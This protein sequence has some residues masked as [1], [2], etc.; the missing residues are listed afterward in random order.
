MLAL[1]QEA[2]SL[3]GP[4]VQRDPLSA[5]ADVRSWVRFTQAGHI[6][7]TASERHLPVSAS[8]SS[9]LGK[10]ENMSPGPLRRQE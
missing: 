2:M 8:I 9:L 5:S 7:P 4:Q 6:H 10:E 3:N 1:G